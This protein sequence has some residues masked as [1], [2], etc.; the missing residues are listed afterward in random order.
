MKTMVTFEAKFDKRYK[1]MYMNHIPRTGDSV[2][3]DSSDNNNPP[4]RYK[5][6]HVHFVFEESASLKRVD[7]I[8]ENL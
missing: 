4:K 8:L 2:T 5:V 1:V 7:V 3:L 6:A